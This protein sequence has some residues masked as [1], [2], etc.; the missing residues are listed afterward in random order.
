MQ[1][2]TNACVKI[3][4]LEIYSEK[5]TRKSVAG[6]LKNIS[7][8]TVHWWYIKDAFA[9][10]CQQISEQNNSESILGKIDKTLLLS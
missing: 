7:P 6:T 4:V 2:I 3:T 5:K 1:L 9:E 10:F 8:V